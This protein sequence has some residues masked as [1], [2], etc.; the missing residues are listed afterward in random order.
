MIEYKNISVIY[1]GE[2]LFGKLNLEIKRNSKVLIVGKSGYGK[3]TLF[4]ILLGFYKPDSGDVLFNNEKITEE[5]IWEI[6]K[7]IAYV[8]QS[9]SLQN[10]TVAEWFD[11]VASLKANKSIDFSKKRILE[12]FNFFQLD[13]KIFNEKIDLLSGGEKQRLA[14][15]TAILLNR[16]IYLLDEPTSALDNK[17]KKMVVE[18]F[19]SFENKTIIVISHDDIWLNQ[20][21][22]NVFDLENKKWVR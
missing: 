10:L 22:F 3:S 20:T 5:N 11:Y 7:K 4:S 8:D 9:V 6:R 21:S 1:R 12:K 17:L 2:D 18:Y 15:I 14:L 16:E 13:E 19:S